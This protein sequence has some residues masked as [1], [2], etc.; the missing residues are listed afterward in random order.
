[1]LCRVKTQSK[2]EYYHE[3]MAEFRSLQRRLE[4]VVPPESLIIIQNCV[5]KSVC[6]CLLL[7]YL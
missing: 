7:K 1:M 4:S 2:V 6:I 3:N 5:D